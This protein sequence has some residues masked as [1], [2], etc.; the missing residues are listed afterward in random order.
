M[1][2]FLFLIPTLLL[3]FLVASG[4][5]DP[6]ALKI[7]DAFSAKALSAPS[8]FM[9]FMLTTN[10]QLENTTDTL[11]GSV[12]ISKDK[13]KLELPDNQVWFDGQTSWS[14]LP[15]EKEV[16]VTNPS[17]K[18]DDS[19][20]S[21]PSAVFTAY[22][23]G[24]KNRLIEEN[25]NAYVIDLYPEDIKTDIVRIRLTI[26]KPINDLKTVEYKNKEG[27]VYTLNIKEYSLN[28]RPDPST[29]VFQPAK[30]KGVDVVDMR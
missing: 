26:G 4:Q 30:F 29:F 11:S 5:N 9:K 8:V 3:T 21:R 13:Y 18:K 19:F 12:I 16:T 15:A 27:L 10:D 2:K 20:Q 6:Q 23:K 22:K 28:Q 7:L 14:Y 25:A 17:K 1:K 24:Y